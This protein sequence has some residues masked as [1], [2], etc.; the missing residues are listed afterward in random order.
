MAR[1][2]S[3]DAPPGAPRRRGRGR[4]NSDQPIPKAGQFWIFRSISSA[5][6]T[7]E[8]GIVAILNVDEYQGRPVSILK[9]FI[10]YEKGVELSNRRP[11]FSSSP[12]PVSIGSFYANYK[13]YP[14]CDLAEAERKLKI[15]PESLRALVQDG[16]FTAYSY[17]GKWYIPVCELLAFRT[18]RNASPVLPEGAPMVAA[19]SSETL[20]APVVELQKAQFD[21]LIEAVAERVMVKMARFVTAPEFARIIARRVV[22]EMNEATEPDPSI[23]PVA[24]RSSPKIAAEA[25]VGEPDPFTDGDAIPDADESVAG[26]PLVPPSSA[27]GA[28][29]GGMVYSKGGR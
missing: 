8:G 4:K 17:D 3:S 15:D 23:L 24:P 6:A 18:A 27:N 1:I 12:R 5:T 9:L 13:P 14:M 11:K 10:G 2:T 19:R 22:L 28:A 16:T 7:S 21:Q 26:A 29:K 25:E 20:V